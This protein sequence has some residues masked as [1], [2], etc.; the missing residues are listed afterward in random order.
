MKQTTDTAKPQSNKG[1]TVKQTEAEKK[2]AQ[3]EAARLQERKTVREA[4]KQLPEL[5]LNVCT[6]S[7]HPAINEK[8]EQMKVGFSLSSLFKSIGQI[9]DKV[10]SEVHF[11]LNGCLVTLPFK[12]SG[13]ARAKNFIRSLVAAA[14]VKQ[15]ETA[16]NI[17]TAL[18]EKYDFPIVN[19]AGKFIATES[20]ILRAMGTHEKAANS[21]QRLA[22]L[23]VDNF[24]FNP[25]KRQIVK[26]VQTIFKAY[27][28]EGMAAGDK[29]RADFDDSNARKLL[30]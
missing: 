27:K 7:K 1:V 6:E 10:N 20:E 30:S 25:E 2:A 13:G 21:L 5:V 28:N 18:R 14:M 24:G 9:I 19:E 8:G 23:R 12:G 26:N 15:D 22:N 17:A 16:V 11:Y 4:I 29:A 3:R